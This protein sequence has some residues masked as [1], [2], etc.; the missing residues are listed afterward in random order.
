MATNEKGELP[1]SVRL[2]FLHPRGSGQF[3]AE[4][5]RAT[6][7]RDALAGL[8]GAGFVE[9]ATADDAYGL[10]LTRTRTSLPLSG[11]LIESGARSGDT[12]QIVLAQAAAARLTP[13][14]L[15]DRLALDYRVMRGLESPHIGSVRAFHGTARREL[16]HEEGLRGMAD[17]YVVELEMPIHRAPGNLVERATL[18]L[19]LRTGGNYPFHAP[20]AQIVSRPVPFSPHVHPGSG[21]VCIGPGW[22]RARGRMLAAQLVIHVMRV[23]NFDEPATNDGFSRDAFHYATVTLGGRPFTPSL[24]YP[25]LPVETAYGVA[26]KVGTFRAI[27]RA[28]AGEFLRA[29]VERPVGFRAIGRAS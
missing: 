3:E 12:V 25:T 1:E 23:L 28:G 16:S 13:P 19:S 9:A 8:T 6:T 29:G 14:Q 27:S 11:S 24:R 2:V 18:L 22:S 17:R 7:G 4:I 10:E 5:D 26:E 15:R 20:F 21:S